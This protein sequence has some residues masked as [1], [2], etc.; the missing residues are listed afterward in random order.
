MKNDG[1]K[2]RRFNFKRGIRSCTQED[3]S[4]LEWLLKKVGYGGNPEHKRNP[5]DFGL[6]PPSN[7]HQSKSLCD[8]AK[9]FN[10]EFA[11]YLLKEG[12]R[13]GLISEQTNEHNF[14]QNI[15]SV[16]EMEN[17]V[18]IPLESQI[19]NPYA[20]VYHG[21]PIPQTDPKYDEVLKRWKESKC[22]ISE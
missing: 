13:H 1:Q 18:K 11:L 10:R 14:P 4:Y 6:T 15:W 9:V 21:Y 16:I 8:V 20:G 12:V 17:G 5:G 2:R 19:E 7:P 3:A 22:L